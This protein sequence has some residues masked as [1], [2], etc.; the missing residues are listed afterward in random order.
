[1]LPWH[2]VNFI[3]EYFGYIWL[4]EEIVTNDLDN[5]S[6]EDSLLTPKS[7]FF[8]ILGHL[9]AAGIVTLFA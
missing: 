8:S 4:I 6:S 2:K 7:T 3:I 5:C 1:M 9:R